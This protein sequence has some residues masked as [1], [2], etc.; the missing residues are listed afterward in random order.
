M[1]SVASKNCHPETQIDNIFINIICLKSSSC[2]LKATISDEL[3]QFLLVP[4]VFCKPPTKSPIFTSKIGLTLVKEILFLII[5]SLI[6]VKYWKLRN[7]IQNRTLGILKNHYCTDFIF[8]QLTGSE[9]AANIICSLNI[10]KA[11]GL[12][13]I[14]KKIFI[15]WHYH[16]GIAV[17]QSKNSKIL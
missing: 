4:N 10:N 7:I 12:F 1:E 2:N 14:P 9:E 17:W 15:L 6:R 16:T 8:I 5:F 13:S 11:S 3:P